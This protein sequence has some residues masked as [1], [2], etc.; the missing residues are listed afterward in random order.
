M[1]I[2]EFKHKKETICYIEKIEK[3]FMVRTGKPTD[4]ENLEWECKNI[5]SAKII[6][7]QYHKVFVKNQIKL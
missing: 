3:L 4:N 7:N 5:E 6:A 1:I 2:E